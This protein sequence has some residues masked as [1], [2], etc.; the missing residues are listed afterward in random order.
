M[1]NEG[2][3]EQE[4]NEQQEEHKEMESKQRLKKGEMTTLSTKLARKNTS[5][6]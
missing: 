5:T 6:S 3:S 1:E 4:Y 2:G